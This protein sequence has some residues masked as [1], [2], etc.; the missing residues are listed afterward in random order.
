MRL[1]ERQRNML[2]ALEHSP[3]DPKWFT[4]GDS[5]CA[6]HVVVTYLDYFEEHGLIEQGERVCTI[7]D[8]GRDLLAA[9]AAQSPVVATSRTHCGAAMPNWTPP[10]WEAARRGADDHKQHRSKGLGA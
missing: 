3:R 2:R 1:N 9:E 4:H 6:P 10:K 7:T 5:P 8:K